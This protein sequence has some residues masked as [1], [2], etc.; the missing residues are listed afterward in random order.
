[1]TI[2]ERC[3]QI[4]SP[5]AKV[6]VKAVG[7]KGKRCSR[8][9]PLNG[10]TQTGVKPI[11]RRKKFEKGGSMLDSHVYV[12]DDQ[13]VMKAEQLAPELPQPDAW[14]PIDGFLVKVEFR[15]SRP[16]SR[17]T[18]WFCACSNREHQN[19]SVSH[20]QMEWKFVR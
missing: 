6:D 9:K 16:S 4:S 5:E 15:Y 19:Q 7:N 3:L 12:L 8:S 10:Q 13:F 11:S 18:T 1:M 2:R 14:F 17:R 20:C